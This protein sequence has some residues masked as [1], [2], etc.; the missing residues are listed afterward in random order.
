[1]TLL[2]RL[3]VTMAA[4]VL[5]MTVALGLLADRSF[6]LPVLFAGLA[7]ELGILI[8]TVMVAHYYLSGPLV[9]MAAP[10]RTLPQAAPEPARICPKGE[11]GIVARA[12][13]RMADAVGRGRPYGQRRLSADRRSHAGRRPRRRNRWRVVRIALCT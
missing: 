11:I 5:A 9:E 13:D 2:M 6:D 1:M 10:S 4:L 12:F 7:V 3:T 8:L